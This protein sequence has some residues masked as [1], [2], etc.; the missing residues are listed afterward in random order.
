MATC[1]PSMAAAMA[2][3]QRSASRRMG[4]TSVSLWGNSG[5]TRSTY[6]P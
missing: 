2:M 3:R 6:T 4:V 5:R 1:L